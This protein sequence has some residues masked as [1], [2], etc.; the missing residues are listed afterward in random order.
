[1]T[2]LKAQFP[3][4]APVATNGSTSSSSRKR[5]RPR[6]VSPAGPAIGWLPVSSARASAPGV[7]RAVS[8][9]AS[10]PGTWTSPRPSSPNSKPA[11]PSRPSRHC[12]PSA[13]HSTLRPTSCSTTT[14]PP[15]GDNQRIGR[16]GNRRGQQHVAYDSSFGSRPSS[17]PVLRVTHR[18]LLTA[19]AP[20]RSQGPRLRFGRD[21]ESLTAT[22]SGKTDFMFVR[23]DVGG[24]STL[25]GRLIRH[26]GTE[27]GFV[28][29][30]T[31]EITWI[32]DLPP[33][34]RDSISFDSSRP[35]R[36]A[37]AATYRS[38]H[39]VNL[40]LLDHE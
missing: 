2:F 35:H 19:G 31:L 36:L 4:R 21:V 12:S 32:R 34:L 18:G 6:Q 23:Y 22:R 9:F 1:M 13:R 11:R 39:L 16:R 3:G 27:Y 25:E 5:R 30:G 26:V 24:S 33:H 38:S 29:S 10:S 8:P 7:S 37:N 28:L 17:R 20:G 15:K 40:E 14:A